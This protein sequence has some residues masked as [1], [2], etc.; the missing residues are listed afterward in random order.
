[1]ENII[2]KLKHMKDKLDQ[3]FPYRDN[4]QIQEDFRDEFLRLSHQDNSLNGDFNDYCMNI[5]GTLSYVL[6]GKIN[7]IPNR[8]IEVLQLSFFDS[9]P[10]YKFLESRISN[11]SDFF[12]EYKNFEDTRKLLMQVLR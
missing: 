5:A 3:P 8:Q 2:E 9:F 7:R 10:Q 11:Y 12:E 4:D 6:A 1:M